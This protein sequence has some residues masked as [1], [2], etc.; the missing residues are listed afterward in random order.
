MQKKRKVYSTSKVER[1]KNGGGR[2][3]V[4]EGREGGKKNMP[5]T[6]KVWP[7]LGDCEVL[8]S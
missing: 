3:E 2:N 6:I 7:C 8:V 1:S 4:W 5:L